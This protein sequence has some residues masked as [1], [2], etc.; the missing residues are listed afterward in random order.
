MK[1]LSKILL[2][3]WRTHQNSCNYWSVNLWELFAVFSKFFHCWKENYISKKTH[4]IL[5]IIPSLCCR[6]TLRNLDIRIYDNLQN[7]CKQELSYRKQIVRK[8]RRQNVEGIYRPKYY[9][10]T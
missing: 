4:V 1:H 8:L 6:T 10:V 7:E 9:T 3:G 2:L 5:P